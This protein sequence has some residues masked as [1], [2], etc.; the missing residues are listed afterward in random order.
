MNSEVQGKEFIRYDLMWY[1]TMSCGV[2][3]CGVVWCGVVWYGVRQCMV[4]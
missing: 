4:K 1:H 3:W 2:V